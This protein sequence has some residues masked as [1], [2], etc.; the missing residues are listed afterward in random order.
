M[1]C[2]SCGYEWEKKMWRDYIYYLSKCPRCG[3]YKVITY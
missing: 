3:S 2:L 1:K